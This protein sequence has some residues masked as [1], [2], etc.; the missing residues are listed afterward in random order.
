MLGALVLAI[1]AFVAPYM[2]DSHLRLA[3]CKPPATQPCRS[4]KH[5]YRSSRHRAM[6]GR[7]ASIWSV[8]RTPSGTQLGIQRTMEWGVQ[9][10]SHWA[11]TCPPSP[12]LQTDQQLGI[13]GWCARRRAVAPS[14]R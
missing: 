12:P 9:G 2:H 11:A 14:Q 3:T 10:G 13:D 1:E 8:P 4:A 5:D 6:C 7:T